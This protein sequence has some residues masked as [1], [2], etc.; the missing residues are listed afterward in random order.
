MNSTLYLFVTDKKTE[1]KIGITNNIEDRYLLI[2]S[3]WGDIDIAL[4][5]M[6]TGDRREI[7]RLEKTLHFLLERWQIK[8]IPKNEGHSEWFSMECFDKAIEIIGYYFMLRGINLDNNIIRGISIGHHKKHSRI[9]RTSA[10]IPIKN[11]RAKFTSTTTTVVLRKTGNS[12][13]IVIPQSYVEQN[14]LE[15]G[16]KLALKIAGQELIVKPAK[17]RRSLAELLAATPD[18]LQRVEGWDEMPTVGEEW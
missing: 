12:L 18:G 13:M 8:K 5:C 2:T 15:A 4:S 16:S 1:F 10:L 11:R 7:F 14:H 6:I 9:A 17:P 3:I